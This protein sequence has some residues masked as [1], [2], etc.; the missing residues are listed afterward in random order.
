MEDDIKTEL[1][2]LYSESYYEVSI[3]VFGAY[4]AALKKRLKADL[5]ISVLYEI[6]TKEKIDLTYHTSLHLCKIFM[7]RGI[8]SDRLF[9]HFAN[10]ENNGDGLTKREEKRTAKEKISIDYDCIKSKYGND[11]ESKLSNFDG[12]FAECNKAIKKSYSRK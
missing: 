5:M 1:Q 6:A 11:V 9:L 7:S 2:K 8:L 4:V 12:L 10:V 3:Y